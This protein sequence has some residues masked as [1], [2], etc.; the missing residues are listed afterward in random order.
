MSKM[1]KVDIDP[2]LI[3]DISPNYYDLPRKAKKGEK[4][5]VEREITRA[6]NYYIKN[7]KR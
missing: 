1:S 4:K 7:Y 3:M 6:L 2:K 5:R